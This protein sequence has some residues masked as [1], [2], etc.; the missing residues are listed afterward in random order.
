[1][2]IGHDEDLEIS[3]VLR[4]QPSKLDS[5]ACGLDLCPWVPDSVGERAD[6]S[7]YDMAG[8][9]AG[10]GRGVPRGGRWASGVTA[11]CI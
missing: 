7:N 1:M 9:A 3:R 10:P 4:I 5:V 8:A 11:T 6:N 2:H